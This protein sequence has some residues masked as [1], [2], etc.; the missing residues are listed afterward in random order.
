MSQLTAYPTDPRAIA[1][2]IGEAELIQERLKEIV[3]LLG[4]QS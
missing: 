1:Y 4:V 2:C 3:K